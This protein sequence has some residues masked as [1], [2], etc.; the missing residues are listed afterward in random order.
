MENKLKIDQD[1]L[2]LAVQQG[3]GVDLKKVEFLLRGWGGDCYQAE[4]ENGERYFLKLHDEA[5]YMGIA[6]T[7][8]PFYLPLMH[9]LH[10]KNIL[11]HIP[12][13]VLTCKGAFSLPI[14]HHELVITNFIEGQV[15]GFGKLP[16]PILG[17]LAK[18]VGIL[19]HSRSQ[20]ECRYPFIEQFEIGFEM[21][22]VNSFDTVESI[23]SDDRPGKQLLR[24]T[25]LPHKDEVLA[26]LHQLKELQTSVRLIDKPKVICHTDLHG[27]NL[28]TDNRNNLY[29]LDWEN[30]LIAPMEHDMIFF[31]GEENFWEIFWPNYTRQFSEPRINSEILRFYFYRRTL[32][33]IAGFVLR[34]LQGE[35]SPER[36]RE[37]IGWL[38]GCLGEFDQIENTISNIRERFGSQLP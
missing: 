12:H 6:A 37:D 10:H 19:H 35:G 15:V 25:L 23:S 30:A 16:E 28:I 5:N 20:L 33:D 18:M 26:N 14:D 22:L 31:A 27:A 1:K 11:P 34:I 2:I 32:E 29:I 9:Q 36:D 7:S 8:R 17:Q 3:Y 21:D 13:P 24:Q 4:I 38:R